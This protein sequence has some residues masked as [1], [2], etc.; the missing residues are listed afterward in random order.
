[1]FRSGGSIS[2]RSARKFYRYRRPKLRWEALVMNVKRTLKLLC[3]VTLLCGCV[4]GQNFI[5][6]TLQ[7]IVLDPSNAAVANAQ[8]EAKSLVTGVVRTTITSP[9]GIF[10][11]NSMEAGKYD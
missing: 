7:G 1:M 10:V 4:F 2:I 11:F 8:V 3:A 9:E 5:T 6:G